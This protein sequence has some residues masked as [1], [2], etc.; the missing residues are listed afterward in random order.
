[1]SMSRP[2]A[3]DT[4]AHGT[5]IGETRPVPF[6]TRPVLQGRLGMVA[7]G[8]Y[9]AAAIGLSLLERGGNAIDAGVAAGFAL[10]LM[11]PQ[12]VGI[13]GEVPI[14]IHLAGKHKSV[15]ITG[16]G[17]APRAASI[18]WFRR[19]GISLIPSDGFLPATVPAQF[20]SWCTALLEFGTASLA[21][22]LG[23][24]VELAEGGFA[25]YPA[26]RNGILKVRE[27]YKTEWPT[28][29]A[30][31]LDGSGQPP[32]DGA[33]IRNPDWARTLKGAIDTSLRASAAGRESAI[34]GAI[35]YF[36]SGPVARKAVEFSSNNAFLDD[37][38]EA[39]SGLLSLEDFADFGAR[40]IRVEDPVNRDYRGVEVL[41]CGPWSQGP[42]FLQQLALLEGFDLRK[43]GH[44]TAEY[45]HVYLECAKLAFADR[46]RY[47]GDPGF[48]EVPLGLLLSEDYAAERRELID[49]HHASLELRPGSIAMT[50][51]P[52]G[53]RWPAVTGDTTHVDAVDRWGNLFSATPSGGWIGSSP[54]V[55]GL[56]FPL[57]TRGQMFYLDERHANALVPGKR[58]RTTLTPSLALREGEPWLAFG[59]PGGDQQDQWSLQFFLNVIDFGM[60]LQEALDAPTVQT[61]HFPGSFYPHASQPGGVRAE[62]RIPPEVCDDLSARGH[63]LSLD[64]PW[65]HGQ[66]TVV[67]REP[68]GLVSGA[69][70]PRGR[71]AYVM[72]R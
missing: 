63:K 70:S 61:T 21:D 67:A 33:L 66:V 29:A 58:P 32:P 68:N 46:E 55:E 24:A 7:A 59:T 43:L 14:L 8:H 10:S 51:A 9:L 65:S 37:S 19:N 42:V 30:I 47:Y 23:P 1:M 60:D 54:V 34:Q 40:G 6:A 16:Q 45:L 38:G 28:S 64:G 50:A 62:S 17:W 44:N 53:T 52:A 49:R 57:G 27:R 13:G 20:A 41:K 36:Y 18:D 25:M 5:A 2:F 15:A 11:K 72:G 12:S 69:A 39:H 31:Y 4:D 48:V 3:P 22:V 35:D 56:G 71:V 26:L